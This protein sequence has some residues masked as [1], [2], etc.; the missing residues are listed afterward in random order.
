[1]VEDKKARLFF[2]SLQPNWLVCA[3]SYVGNSRRLL[4]VWDPHKLDLVSYLSCGGIFMI[5][6]LLEDKRQI[7]FL[8]CYEPCLERKLFWDKLVSRGMLAHKNLIVV[9]DLNFT[10]SI[11]EVWGDTAKLD[12]TS[13]YF[14]GIFQE[15]HLVD[16]L[17]GDVVPTWR[18]GRVGR[19]EISK[20][21][22]RVYMS[23]DSISI[24]GRHRSWVAYPYISD[25]APIMLQ[26]D[27]SAYITAYPFKLNPTWLGEEDF[28][29]LVPRGVECADCLG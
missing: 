22:D 23:Q 6:T 7:A 1:M 3:V 26:F 9:G 10:V 20:R 28:R 11:G 8:N 25:H 5:G 12:P 27:N 13:G 24:V 19:D 29:I 18:N 21:L 2:T 15:N 14:K 16:I 17:P 4:V